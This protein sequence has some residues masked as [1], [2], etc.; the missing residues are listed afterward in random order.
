M[1]LTLLKT[2]A[3]EL[4]NLWG[5]AWARKKFRVTFFVVLFGFILSLYIA[6][7]WLHYNETRI[8]HPLYD[9]ILVLFDPIDLNTP[10]FYITNAAMLIGLV[11]A[12]LLPFNMVHTMLSITMLAV[13]RITTMYL[14]PL[15]APLEIIPLRDP[16]IEFAFYGEQVLTKDLFFSGHTASLILLT[17]LCPFKK[18]KIYLAISAVA[19]GLMLILQH[20]HYSIDVFVAPI[21]SLFAYIVCS[22]LTIKILGKPIPKESIQWRLASKLS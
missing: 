1:N 7:L 19:V 21:F 14:V 20:V 9:A 17:L 16:L 15:E 18:I 2:T 13:L 4:T 10:I 12:M 5:K 6:K 11:S 22:R 8:G 3:K